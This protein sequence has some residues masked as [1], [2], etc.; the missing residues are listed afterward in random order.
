MK[1]KEAFSDCLAYA[2]GQ[3]ATNTARAY[4]S[5]LDKFAAY[6]RSEGVDADKDD[7]ANV[8]ADHFI[9]FPA[10]LAGNFA[11]KTCRTYIAGTKFFL[12]WMVLEKLIEPNYSQT[13]RLTKAI[14]SVMKYRADPMP[15]IPA[16]GAVEKMVDAVRQMNEPTPRKERNI[17]LV[18]FLASS[19]T[20]N[21]EARS[22]LVGDF[23]MGER[24]VV[25]TGK[26]KKQRLAFFSRE[27][28]DA[29]REYWKLRG[30]ASPKDPAFARHDKGVGRRH[31]AITT[32]TVRNVVNDVTAIAGIDKGKFTPHYFRHAFAIK[33]LS[34]TGNLALVQDLLGH[35]STDT[36]RVYATI[37]PEDLKAAH[38]RVFRE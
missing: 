24:Q 12:D 33:M 16:R 21:D 15:H 38:E 10:W 34:E 5:S 7:I 18:L 14:E 4:R 2:K 22:L 28:A 1:I 3:R 8:T 31:E 30:F 20:R 36:T 13:V 9:H 23:D 26:R 11:K 29:L 32:V 17:A 27:A 6:L 25:V 35:S 37:Y 19:G